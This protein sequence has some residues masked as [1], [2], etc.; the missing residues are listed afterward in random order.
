[1]IEVR[2]AGPIPTLVLG[3][4][5]SGCGQPDS[6]AQNDCLPAVP[7]SVQPHGDPDRRIEDIIE[8]LTGERQTGDE[9]PVEET[10]D[11]PNYGGVWGDFEGG[12]VVAV[13]DCSDVD[14]DELAEI[15]GG[16]ASLHLIEVPYTFTQVNA[17]RDALVSE[18]ND[19]GVE[20]EVAIDSTLSGRMIEVRVHDLDSLPLSFG[21]G[22]P[23]ELYEVVEG[24]TSTD[25]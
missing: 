12:V 1:M 16:S 7:A 3:L 6:A 22:V 13:L 10:I 9:D 2:A 17:F 19:L 4:A 25:G 21:S 8:H 23:G 14:A 20:G 24:E 18:L 5:L 11:D 15:A